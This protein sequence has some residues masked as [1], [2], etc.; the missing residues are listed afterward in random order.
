MKRSIEEKLLHP[1]P[2]RKVAAAKEAGVDL[3]LLLGDL[4]LTP[5]QRVDKMQRLMRFHHQIREQVNRLNNK[6]NLS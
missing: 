2:G 3:T 5:Q 4:Q 6:P 1:R